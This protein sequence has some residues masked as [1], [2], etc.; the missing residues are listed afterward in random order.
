M[1]N[2]TLIFYGLTDL[3]YIYMDIL[4]F[5]GLKHNAQKATK[6]CNK[7]SFSDIPPITPY[8]ISFQGSIA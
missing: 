1:L 3:E 7:V 4:Y 5:F 8:V 6:K 2:V